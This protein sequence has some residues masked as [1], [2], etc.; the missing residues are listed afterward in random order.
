MNGFIQYLSFWRWLISVS[1]T[2]SRLP[3]Y[4]L[5]EGLILLLSGRQGLCSLPFNVGGL[6]L[7]CDIMTLSILDKR[8]YNSSYFGILT[9]GFQTSNCEE[10]PAVHRKAFTERNWV[11]HPHPQPQL[12]PICQLAPACQPWDWAILKVPWQ[13]DK[14]VN[15]KW[16]VAIRNIWHLTL[17]DTDKWKIAI[18]PTKEFELRTRCWGDILGTRWITERAQIPSSFCSLNAKFIW[19]SLSLYLVV[20]CLKSSFSEFQVPQHTGLDTPGGGTFA[21]TSVSTCISSCI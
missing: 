21:Q 18:N 5:L 1:L 17:S 11:P 20:L 2:S 12:G 9:F 8:H 10:A 16:N 19:T 13:R 6:R 14:N 4:T 7:W 3:H 15:K